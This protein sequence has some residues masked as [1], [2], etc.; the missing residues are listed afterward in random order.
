MRSG[1]LFKTGNI[2]VF[3]NQ[4]GLSCQR[5]SLIF[6]CYYPSGLAF[7]QQ[8]LGKTKKTQPEYFWHPIC[9][10]NSIW[11]KSELILELRLSSLVCIEACSFEEGSPLMVLWNPGNTLTPWLLYLLFSFACFEVEQHLAEKR[12][13]GYYGSLFS[14]V[15]IPFVCRKV[16]DHICVCM[17]ECIK[18]VP[19]NMEHLQH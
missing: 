8:G 19:F 14:E 16:R 5:K 9:L 6:K 18:S 4:C 15:V 11:S 17:F 1:S 12:R 7:C 2:T 13:R 3:Y 10:D